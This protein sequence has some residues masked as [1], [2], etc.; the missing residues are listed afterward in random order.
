MSSEQRSSYDGSRRACFGS[1]G[2]LPALRGILPRVQMERS[3]GGAPRLRISRNAFGNMPDGASRVL[4]LPDQQRCAP[5]R[6]RM[7]MILLCAF[8]PLIAFGQ[9]DAEFTKANQ[10]YAQGHF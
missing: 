6:L 3:T 1:A 2:M 10:E 9:S 4:A 7:L 5:F 8:F